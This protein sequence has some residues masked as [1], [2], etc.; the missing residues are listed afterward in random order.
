[1]KEEQVL[2]PLWRNCW[3]KK[4][5]LIKLSTYTCISML[6]IYFYAKGTHYTYIYADI[7]ML[8]GEDTLIMANNRWDYTNTTAFS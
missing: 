3:L 6:A 7:I 2:N 5:L 4:E 1:M 8:I